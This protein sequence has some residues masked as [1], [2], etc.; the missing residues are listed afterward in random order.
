MESIWLDEDEKTLV[1][2]IIDGH[3]SVNISELKKRVEIVVERV[4]MPEDPKEWVQDKNNLNKYTTVVGNI[5]FTAEYLKQGNGEILSL[6]YQ[7]I[8]IKIT[9]PESKV[10]GVGQNVSPNGQ[11]ILGE[12]EKI[13][14]SFPYI[15]NNIP[16]DKD[17]KAILKDSNGNPT[18]PRRT[19]KKLS[20][21]TITIHSTGNNSSTAKNEM[22][23]LINLDNSRKA[24]FHIVVDEKETIEVIPLK[25]I[26]LHCGN[27]TGNNSSIGVEFCH[28]GNRE[29]TLKNSIQLT[30]KLLQDRKWNTKQ[31]KRHKEW[32][33]KD[34]LGILIVENLR[35]KKHQTWEWFI[36]EVNKLL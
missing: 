25:E 30:A 34:C 12:K 28:S 20:S 24:S 21:T 6:T 29:K 18:L 5:E 32:A 27:T 36:E 26:A 23:W 8:K 3:S 11:G 4:S 22:S 15:V 17:N 7:T 31:L 14:L 35:E 2:Y 9:K 33:T 19:G 16:L 10:K 13:I 1:K